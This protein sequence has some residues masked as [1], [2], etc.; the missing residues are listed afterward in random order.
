M[1]V[2]RPWLGPRPLSESLWEEM[3][4]ESSSVIR[5]IIMAL[6]IAPFTIL[7]G[8]PNYSTNKSSIDKKKEISKFQNKM[9][10]IGKHKPAE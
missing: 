5:L 9:Y 8:C 2:S 7:R 6:H 1:F 10:N 4:A 3:R